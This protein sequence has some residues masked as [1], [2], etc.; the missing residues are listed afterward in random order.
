MSFHLFVQFLLQAAFEKAF[1]TS[2]SVV[3]VTNALDVSDNA[4]DASVWGQSMA[5]DNRL[6][7]LNTEFRQAGF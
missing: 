4:V 7:F 2:H 5:L 1:E 3:N 6:N